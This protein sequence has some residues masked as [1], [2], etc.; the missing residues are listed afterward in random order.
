MSLR[1]LPN[2]ICIGRILLVVPI[3][4]A[5]YRGEFALTLLLFGV[6][7][8]SDALDG[9]LAKRFGWTTELGKVLDPLADKLLLVTVFITLTAAGHTPLWLTFVVVARDVIIGV[10]ALAYQWLFGPLHGRPTLVSKLNTGMQLL[11]VL[12]AVASLA[13]GTPPR[14]IV[15]ALG[16]GVFVT[17]VVSGIDYIVTYIRRAA[18]VSQARRPA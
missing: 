5:L 2:T 4:M 11:Y 10:G 3:A 7:A 13:Y 8:F 15:L 17:T 9:F 1:Q 14:G 16:A 6:A 18:A 12:A